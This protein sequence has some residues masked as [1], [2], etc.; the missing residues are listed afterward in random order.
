MTNKISIILPVD[1]A[2]RRR[3][4]N[5]NDDKNLSNQ[6]FSERDNS[7]KK[8]AS[9]FNSNFEQIKKNKLFKTSCDFMLREIAGE[10]VLIPV[11]D[12]AEQ[13][14]G[15]LSLNETFKYIW[16]QFEQAHTIEDVVLKTQED[17]DDVNGQIE[18]DICRF[19]EECFLYGL[20]KEEE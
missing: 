5:Q 3:D 19:V 4:M 10:F 2:Y 17:F 11:G 7:S 14:N 20:I 12:G 9:V 18:Y 13:L 6:L 1:K 8:T 15:M 16:N